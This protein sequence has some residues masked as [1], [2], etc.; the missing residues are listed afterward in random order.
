MLSVL[1][2]IGFRCTLVC[3]S[4]HRKS[5]RSGD[6]A[7]LFE[8]FEVLGRRWALRVVWELGDEG[9]TYRELAA[10]I[11]GMSTSVLTDRLRDLR[12][13]GLAEHQPGAGYRLSSRGH[14]LVA[15]LEPLAEWAARY[16]EPAEDQR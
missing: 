6:E 7:A 4:M 1:P 15:H 5:R 9:L 2:C 11:P 8:L 14:G 12:A 10:R 16:R 3:V 13:A